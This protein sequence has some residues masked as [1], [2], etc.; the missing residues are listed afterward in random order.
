MLAM[1]QHPHAMACFHVCCF[2][3]QHAAAD[4]YLLVP[5]PYASTVAC[6]LGTPIHTCAIPSTAMLL[7]GHTYS[8]LWYVQ[9]RQ[10][11]APG[12]TCLHACRVPAL[13][14]SD[15]GLH[16]YTHTVSQNWHMVLFTCLLYPRA[17]TR[18]TGMLTCK[19][20]GPAQTRVH[21]LVMSHCHQ[22]VFVNVLCSSAATCSHQRWVPVPPCHVTGALVS[23]LAAS[24]HHP[25]VTWAHLFA[26]LLCPKSKCGSLTTPICTS[27]T[28]QGHRMAA[29]ACLSACVLIIPPGGLF[30]SVY[31]YIVFQCYHM[32]VWTHL[33]TCKLHPW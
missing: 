8:H 15:I 29:D 19:P 31:T 10:V 25:T 2:Q 33:L 21:M 9:C 20:N 14:H 12:C 28:C 1:T 26:C 13:P 17:T 7:S 18:S 11:V 22:E 32:V 6:S 5:L 27:S 16:V 24:Y 3:C 23:L 30:S 4:A